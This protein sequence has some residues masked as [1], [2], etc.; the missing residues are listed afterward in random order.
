M[1][2]AK[3][4]VLA[5]GDCP[6]CARPGQPLYEGLSDGFGAT[7]NPWSFRQCPSKSCG[8]VWLDPAPTPTDL[9][10]AYHDYPVHKADVLA[11]V[12][13]GP[14]LAGRLYRFA[15]AVAGIQ[16]QRR[17]LETFRLPAGSG[18][19]LLEV[20]CG[21]GAR[22]ALL[23][24]LGYEV[25][26]QDVAPAAVTRTAARGQ[27]VHHGELGDL[28]LPEQT[29][30]IIVMNHVLEHVRDSVDFLRQIHRLLR[31]GGS[32][33]SIQPN[34]ISESHRRFGPDWVGLDPPRHLHVFTPPST[35]AVAK[36]AGFRNVHV[37]T[38]T[39]RREHWTRESLRRRAARTGEPAPR[40]IET[41]AAFAQ[42][43]AT[44]MAPVRPWRG[45]EI[46]LH[47]RR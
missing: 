39:A 30:D 2:H 23:E 27:R 45:D 47:A 3:I 18:A 32:F 41:Q 5:V 21:S 17:R 9:H 44:I 13:H 40:D 1:G 24:A 33:V 31:P 25:E 6:V 8:H 37:A 43:L 7:A 34:G 46:V 29:Y 4:A 20:G 42:G 19:R 35:I 38:T 10:L 22:L 12:S 11:P 14:G 15:L 28:K 36:A 16:A 26:G